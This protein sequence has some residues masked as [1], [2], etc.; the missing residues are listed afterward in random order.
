MNPSAR[1]TSVEAVEQLHATLAR[2]SVEAQEALAAA[3]LEVRRGLDALQ[4]RLAFW[5]RTVEKCHEEVN[6]CRSDLAHRR[7]LHG[8]GRTGASEQEIALAKAQ[9][10]MRD[11]QDKVAVCRKW[12]VALPDAVTDYEGPTRQ[13]A[14]TV[15][16]DL[17]A[18]LALLKDKIG[19]LKAYA[20]L[21]PPAAEPPPAA[22]PSPP[23]GGTP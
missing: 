2:F 10:R 5:Q 22:P 17:R 9:A 13:L 1:V 20:A 19:V 4:D 7:S 6:R 18:S 8:G 14:G 11:A 15:D 3:D 12:L 21:A 16:A 23:P